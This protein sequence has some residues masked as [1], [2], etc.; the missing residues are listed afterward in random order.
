MMAAAVPVSGAAALGACGGQSTA[1]STPQPH[2]D[3]ATGRETDSSL[4]DANAE[5]DGGD[6]A[7]TRTV[8]TS[9]GETVTV[10]L[11]GPFAGSLCGIP[12][13]FP[14]DAGAL[15]AD[16][17]A[18]AV[19][20]GDGG[21]THAQCT[22]LCASPGSTGSQSWES[23]APIEDGGVPLIQCQP[24]GCLG[25]LPEGLVSANA[26]AATSLGAYFAGMAQLEAASVHAFRHLRR[27]LVAHGAPR[28][29]VRAAE[30]AARDEIRHARVSTA[31]ARR[32]GGATV[33][34]RVE[35]RPVRSL[36]TIALENAVEGCA[37]EGFG[38]L[39]ATWQGTAATDPVIR[40]AMTRLARDETRHAAL[41]FA[42]DAWLHGRLDP[43]AR[44]RVKATRNAALAEL[45]AGGDEV[46]E[47]LRKP[48]GMP[49]RLQ[50]RELG[51]EMA[52]WAA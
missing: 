38:A 16:G 46:P 1:A 29:L 48:L 19:D 37:R 9:C 5:D 42:V 40:A 11:T 49:S 14:F 4:G 22:A 35:P 21:I 51:R 47:A 39:V 32:H 20:A 28:R 33:A 41:A 30:R 2:D 52:R 31:L 8:V 6:G 10:D 44:A 50:W 45:A 15:A 3:A 43:A 23:C 17:D 18:S 24:Y 34:P 12:E 36:E 25:R 7:T 13:C 26:A 27:E